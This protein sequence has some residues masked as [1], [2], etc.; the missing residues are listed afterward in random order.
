MDALDSGGTNDDSMSVGDI[1][2]MLSDANQGRLRRAKSSARTHSSRRFSGLSGSD[3][4]SRMSTRDP[5]SRRRRSSI[6][7]PV[8]DDDDADVDNEDGKSSYPPAPPSRDSSNSSRAGQ[9]SASN[10]TAGSSRTTKSSTSACVESTTV[11]NNLKVELASIKANNEIIQSKTRM[12]TEENCML[13]T[14]L[15]STKSSEAELRQMVANL[16]NQVVL[17]KKQSNCHENEGSYRRRGSSASN[18][19]GGFSAFG[20]AVETLLGSEINGSMDVDYEVPLGAPVSAPIDGARQ[21]VPS[22]ARRICRSL[23]KESLDD[24]PL[25]TEGR[26]APEENVAQKEQT[27]SCRP[28]RARRRESDASTF[29]VDDAVTVQCELN[30]LADENDILREKNAVLAAERDRLRKRLDQMMAVSAATASAI[31]THMGVGGSIADEYELHGKKFEQGYD[32]SAQPQ[33]PPSSIRDFMTKVGSMRN[34]IAGSAPAAFPGPA[35]V[36]YRRSMGSE[37]QASSVPPSRFVGLQRR[38]SVDS[39]LSVDSLLWDSFNDD[40]SGYGSFSRGMGVTAS[41]TSVPEIDEDID[42]QEV[43]TTSE[44]RRTS[45]VDEDD[46]IDL[47]ERDERLGLDD[48][49]T[50]VKLNSLRLRQGSAA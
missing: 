21:Q 18:D 43:G 33:P 36:R 7:R 46:S 16:E 30:N 37:S 34:P 25:D 29:S 11:L 31:P 47:V 50:Y 49:N 17:L 24:R 5:R 8:D 22:L 12:L 23:S 28:R 10:A 2:Q 38:G 9:K 19:S 45:T 44:S 4:S 35:G 48:Y 40:G 41:F 27:Q 1:D 6:T 20:K 39:M 26:L 13:R 3:A 32:D 42:R 14:E 15:C